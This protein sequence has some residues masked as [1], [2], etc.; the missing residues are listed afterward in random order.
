[1]AQSTI[2]FTNSFTDGTTRNLVIGPFT[3]S[4]ISL[5]A[6][7]T[8]VK[9]LNNNSASIA[10]LYLS[11]NGSNFSEISQVKITTENREVIL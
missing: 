9:D 7:R 3:T 2:T 10:S 1:M 5:S 8:A 4:K 6:I 11:E